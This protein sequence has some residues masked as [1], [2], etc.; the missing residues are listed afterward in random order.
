LAKFSKWHLLRLRHARER[1]FSGF[2][3]AEGPLAQ[4][5]MVVQALTTTGY[6]SGCGDV[7][8]APVVLPIGA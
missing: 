2:S 4:E 5:K 3:D 7:A 8:L 1:L 6:A